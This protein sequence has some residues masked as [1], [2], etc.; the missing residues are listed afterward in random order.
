MVSTSSEQI[1]QRHTDRRLEDRT[2]MT[3]QGRRYRVGNPNHPFHEVY[4]EGGHEAVYIAMGFINPRQTAEQIRKAALAMYDSCKEGYIY[5]ISNPAFDGWIKCG[6]AVD[7]YDRCNSLNTGDPYRGYRVEYV[8]FAEDAAK[9]EEQAHKLLED[10]SFDR[11]GEWFDTD[12]VTA[13]RALK[14]LR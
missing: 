3:I 12:I 10:V 1:G 6:R 8:V 7:A 4:K 9:A 5:L 14:K 11:R 13:I 2:R